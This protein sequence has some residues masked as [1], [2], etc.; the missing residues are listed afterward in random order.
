MFYELIQVALGQ[1]E[2]LGRS[3]SD[4]E[5]AELFVL[6]QKQGVVGVALPALEKLSATGV[7]VR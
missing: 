1:R 7:T 4:E 2:K 6:S 5:W 3:P